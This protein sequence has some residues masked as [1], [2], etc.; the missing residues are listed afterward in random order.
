MTNIKLDKPYKDRSLE[1]KRQHKLKEIEFDRRNPGRMKRG[2]SYRSYAVAI[3][4]A[5]YGFECWIKCLEHEFSTLQTDTEK[6]AF[7]RLLKIIK[8]QK[9]DLNECSAMVIEGYG[10]SHYN[11][12]MSAIKKM[13]RYSDFWI[14]DP[15]SWVR[16]SHNRQRQFN[17]LANHL[18]CKYKVSPFMNSCWFNRNEKEISWYIEVGNGQNIRKCPDLPIPFTKK[19]AHILMNSPGNMTINEA[20]RRSQV[21]SLGGDSRISDALSGT[22]LHFFHNRRE[23]KFWETVIRWF[24]RHPM[25]EKDQFGPILDY[26]NNRK[27]ETQMNVYVEGVFFDRYDPPEPGFTIKDRDPTNLMEQVEKWHNNL[28]NENK[29]GFRTS[30]WDSCGIEGFRRVEGKKESPTI[31]KIEEILTGNRLRSEGK[32]MRHCIYSYVTYCLSGRTAV[33]SLTKENSGGIEN[34]LTISVDVAN[35]RV[36]EAR[37]KMNRIASQNE[38]RILQLWMSRVGLS[39]SKYYV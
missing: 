28:N 7:C 35:K 18:F 2:K 38:K 30:K 17:S 37:G 23:E 4:A 21:L 27:F 10:R 11:R 22:L 6:D 9:S 34:I 24:I 12:Y 19:M 33:Y 31:W 25:I 3:D 32:T 16:N 39:A 13:A 15:E 29:T 14:R 1:K 20:M 8:K 26:I 5:R 36:T